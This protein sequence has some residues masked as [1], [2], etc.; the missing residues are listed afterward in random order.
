M[1]IIIV[2]DFAFVNGGASQVAINTARMLAERNEN[3]T[4]FTAVGPVDDC[5]KKIKN[6]EV[7]CLEQYDILNNPSRINAT[8]QGLWNI[9]ASR[10]FK[11]LLARY[12]VDNTIIHVHTLSKAI[13]SSII[14]VA[15]NG[16]Y[17]IVYHIHDY[18]LAC[19]NLGFYNYQQSKIC[20]EEALG[21]KCLFRNCDSRSYLHKCW[22]V[23]RQ[24][25]QKNIGGVPQNIDCYIYI[26]NFSIKILER[27][28]CKDKMKRFLPNIVDVDKND[29]IKVE[30]NSTIAFIG[31]L[32]PEKNPQILARV[33][34]KLG[35]P[36][37]FIGSGISEKEIKKENK[38]AEITGWLSPDDIYEKLKNVRVVVFTSKWYETQGLTVI[39]SL[40]RG[41]PVIVSD[42]TAARDEIIN[43]KNGMLFSCEDENSLASIL[44]QFQDDVLVEKFSRFAYENYWSKYIDED[45]YIKRLKDIYI[46]VLKG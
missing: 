4:L 8:L 34:K 14:P 3:V 1:N 44:Q 38:D 23:L 20:Y 11:N 43:G 10:E 32:S 15:K 39:E 18:G 13:S 40:A 35:M 25:I 5:L 29:R 2:N 26:S 19:P 6:L 37:S 28:I 33:T 24:Y 22:R 31:R 9:K 45:T 42:V 16:G 7:V 17:K 12:S 27:Y 36:V 46:E 21:Y 41:I 30:K